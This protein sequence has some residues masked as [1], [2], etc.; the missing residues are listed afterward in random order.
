MEIKTIY[1]LLIKNK[2]ERMQLLFS[3]SYDYRSN[4]KKSF[5]LLFQTS[6]FLKLL[7]F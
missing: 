7:F 4:N 3:F 5:I 6:Q 2:K 1:K